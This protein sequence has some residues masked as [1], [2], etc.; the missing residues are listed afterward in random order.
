MRHADRQKAIALRLKG[1]SLNEISDSLGAAKSSI[2]LW[3][4]HIRLSQDA[5]HAIARKRDIAREKAAQTYHART[6]RRLED[7][8]QQAL[9]LLSNLHVT[10]DISRLMCALLYWCEGEKL[11][12][13]SRFAFTNSDPFLVATFLKLLRTG[14][15]IDERK[16]RITLHVHEYHDAQKQLRFWSKVT[17][18]PLSQCHRPY[19]K[20]HTGKRTRKDYPGCVAITYFDT[21]TGRR[22]EAIAKAYLAQQGAW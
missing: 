8:H 12:V 19:R 11:R 10:P 15:S 13:G 2:S 14:F 17:K 16:L 20:P 18:I 1:F 22:V 4:R 21:E 3:V 7:A 9:K 6:T 5:R